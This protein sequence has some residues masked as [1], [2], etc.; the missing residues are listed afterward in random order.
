[1]WRAACGIS[2]ILCLQYI[3]LDW[4][5]LC[6]VCLRLFIYLPMSRTFRPWHIQIKSVAFWLYSYGAYILQLL[7]V[8]PLENTIDCKISHHFL[9]TIFLKWLI[10]NLTEIQSICF[11]NLQSGSCPTQVSRKSLS[12]RLWTKSWSLMINYQSFAQKTSDSRD[13]SDFGANYPTVLYDS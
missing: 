8:L 6:F 12:K 9:I 4:F 10:W 11:Q 13:M 1:M 2:H 3:F 7:V 5:M